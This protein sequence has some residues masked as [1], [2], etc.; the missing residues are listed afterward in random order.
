MAP[1]LRAAATTAE[2]L[3]FNVGAKTWAGGT[4]KNDAIASELKQL[5]LDVTTHYY[6]VSIVCLQETNAALSA[7][8]ENDVLGPQWTVAHDPN[9]DLMIAWRHERS[10]EGS[11]EATWAPV[12]P[13][14]MRPL[15]PTNEPGPYRWWRGFLEARG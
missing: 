6:N 9:M 10:A 12:A 4:P 15:W 11:A 3:C 7:L 2:L 1:D 5:L 8:I 14:K 13:I